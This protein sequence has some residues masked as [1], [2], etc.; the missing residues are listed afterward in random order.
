MPMLPLIALA[1]GLGQ[2]ATG[3]RTIAGRI[4][5][6]ITH[7]PIVGVKVTYCCT[8]VAGETDASGS[9]LL[10]VE[11]ASPVSRFTIAKEGYATVRTTVPRG[12]GDRDF[13]LVPS[14]HLSG[15]LVDGDSGE[16][17]AGFLVVATGEGFPPNLHLA[18]PS[19]KDGSFAI[20]GEMTPG[21]YIVQVRPLKEYTFTEG[22]VKGSEEARRGYGLTFFP[23][24]PSAD[25]AA[26]VAVAPGEDRH[27]EIRLMARERFYIAGTIDVPEGRETDTLNVTLI[28][29]GGILGS[30]RE[31]FKPGPFHIDGLA[32]GSYVLAFT[33]RTGAALNQ[34]V[35][36]RNRSIDDL[37]ITLRAAVAIRATVTTLE[38]KAKPPEHISLR[39]L[40]ALLSGIPSDPSDSLFIPGLPPGQY[41]PILSLSAG[42]AV[43]S[44]SY[45]GQPVYDTPILIEAE[46]STVNFVVTSRTAAISGVVRD[47]NQIP[48]PHAAVVVLPYPAPAQ[49]NPF[50]E[51]RFHTSSGANGSFRITD[52]APGSYTV[53]AGNGD[54]QKIDLDFAQ[55]AN[56]DLQ[57]K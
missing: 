54:G 34:P 31:A 12:P 2:A 55:T 44:V 49:I 52:L 28:R 37:T 27:I 16:P 33:T 48:V 40:P 51:R 26:P 4:T 10:H 43:A 42:Y 11:P 5:D 57:V 1:M 23:G 53:V 22:R 39:V 30:S 36:V 18:R 38:E 24:V 20:S 9:F 8:E 46:E 7:Q 41:W 47:A 21:N 29:N 35:E 14:A 56:V 19:G 25:A 13:E 6:A 45:G 50:N 3:D 32:P 15:R 17:L